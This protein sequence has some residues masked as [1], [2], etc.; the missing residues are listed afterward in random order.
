MTEKEPRKQWDADLRRSYS[1][2]GTDYEAAI[3]NAQI[4]RSLKTTDPKAADYDEANVLFAQGVRCA[5]SGDKEQG[6]AQI[7]TAYLLDGRSII[8]AP[9]LPENA[10]AYSKNH[11]LDAELLMDLI[12][13]DT[14]SFG[15]DIFHIILAM[16]MGS[17]SQE[18]IGIAMVRIDKTILYLEDHLE[19]EDPSN[20]IMGGCLTRKALLYQKSS[21][22]MALGDFKNA[23]RSLTKALKIDEFYT[24]ARESRACIWGAKSMKDDKTVH[25]EFKRV[26]SEHHADDRGN[27]VAYAFLVIT[28]LDDSSLGTFD[29]AKGFYEKMIAAIKRKDEIYGKRRHDE[30]P[31]AVHS[32]QRRIQEY[33]KFDWMDSIAGIERMSIRE[34]TKRVCL[35]CGSK[36]RGDG[37]GLNKCGRCK[38]CIF[39]SALYHILDACCCSY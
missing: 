14:Q 2:I 11:L 35:K 8:W 9:K 3:D 36:S 34:T 27:E 4:L 38:V 22:Q 24:Q 30:L 12:H 6:V 26:V 18:V 17:L 28:T 23:M 10:D 33:G 16:H 39:I 21:L 29:D 20:P 32:A 25:A 31:S 19:I 37:Q 7:A 5:R 13:H 15:A 1:H